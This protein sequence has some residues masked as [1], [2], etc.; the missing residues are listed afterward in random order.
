MTSRIPVSEIIAYCNAFGI[1]DIEWMVEMVQ[2]L[3]QYVMS[4][5]L[6]AQQQEETEHKP[7]AHRGGITNTGETVRD[8]YAGKR[9]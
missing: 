7:R 6:P 1:R 8:P 3:D 5:Q 4:R 9:K 2:Q